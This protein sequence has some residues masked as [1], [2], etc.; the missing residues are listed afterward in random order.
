MVEPC[1][2]WLIK[3]VKSSCPWSLIFSQQISPI[4]QNELAKEPFPSFSHLISLNI[5][6]TPE[7]LEF[8]VIAVYIA[9]PQSVDRVYDKLYQVIRYDGRFNEYILSVADGSYDDYGTTDHGRSLETKYY[10]FA[11]SGVSIGYIKGAATGGAV[12][13]SDIGEYYTM[14]AAHLFQEEVVDNTGKITKAV[15]QNAKGCVITQPAY[16]DYVAE[17]R[18]MDRYLED[19]DERLSIASEAAKP[20]IMGKITDTETPL[21]ELTKMTGGMDAFQQSAEYA[22]VE[23]SRYSA[24]DFNGRKVAYDYALAKISNRPV[25]ASL[26]A[27]R[28]PPEPE[29]GQLQHLDWSNSALK[30]FGPLT[31]DL[32]VWKRGR[33]TGVTYGL[34]AGTLG[35][36]VNVGGEV[37]QEYWVLRDSTFVDWKAFAAPSDSG[38]L[39]VSREGVGCGMV[40]GSWMTFGRAFK[41][42]VDQNTKLWDLKRFADLRQDDSS[43]DLSMAMSQ[44]CHRGVIIV[45]DITSVIADSGM[46]L[47]P[48]T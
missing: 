35:V 44:L 30:F 33:E 15:K 20:T 5:P 17:K 42:P 13:K 29:S 27:W 18:S 47:S 39:V 1:E 34:V 6:A 36:K 25:D 19:M 45:C 22:V 14:T 8:P 12:L 9:E 11:Q 38:A 28:R 7:T 24:G 23:K 32:E 43:F 4:I 3:P 21:S 48:V 31:Y 37:T 26:F 10:A 2:N 40:L 16:Q 41:L 46:Q